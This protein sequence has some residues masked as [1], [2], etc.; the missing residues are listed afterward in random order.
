MQIFFIND[1]YKK[2]KDVISKERFNLNL[3]KS[4]FI[5]NNIYSSYHLS[6]H[7]KTNSHN[8]ILG[9]RCLYVTRK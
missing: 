2:K 5:I 6:L 7:F 1:L 3:F 4:T 9:M 8:V